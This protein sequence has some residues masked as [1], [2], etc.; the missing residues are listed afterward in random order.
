MHTFKSFEEILYTV[1]DATFPDIALELFQH[2]AKNNVVYS[3]YLKF[4][5][6]NPASISTLERIPFLPVSFFKS[7]TVVTGN[8]V[9]EATFT[10]SGTTGLSTSRH[11]VQSLS[12]YQRHSERLFESFFGAL[13]QFHILAL[14]PS[15]LER[16]G[17]SLIYMVDHF[18]KQSKSDYSGFY[19]N[20]LDALIKQLELVKNGDRKVLLL[21]VSFALLD[22]A[23]K[24]QI[25]IS[26][27]IV[28]ETGGMKGRRKELIREELHGILT[29]QFTVPVIH[30][31]YGMTELLSQGYSYGNGLF[32][33]PDCMKIVLKD[34]NDPFT[35]VR[36]GR[37]GIINVI[38]LANYYS[39]AFIETQDLGR[40][41]EEG[42]FEILGRADNSDA[43]GC[44]L[45]VG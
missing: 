20:D 24:R 8:W 28:M 21:G 10:S 34:V 40:M 33:L 41:R 31:E 30:S 2:Q 29:Q 35:P 45:L 1:N 22:L 5:K 17:S 43:R 27:C 18:I 26:N 7:H 37:T 15:Y 44:N 23:E 13:D 9:P 42:S 39:C 38:D 14:L 12:F 4:L 25:D 11:L 3:E 16:E 6:I 32:T 19:L 36:D